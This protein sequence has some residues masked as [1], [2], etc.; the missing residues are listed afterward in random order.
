MHLIK[1]KNKSR[2]ED[3]YLITGHE[4]GKIV[5]W[6]LSPNQT[7]PQEYLSSSSNIYLR[8]YS[9]KYQMDNN[10]I[11]ILIPYRLINIYN[12]KTPLR[13]RNSENNTLSLDNSPE[14]PAKIMKKNVNLRQ[15]NR[16]YFSVDQKRMYS[17]TIAGE[18]HQWC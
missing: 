15:I 16:I 1:N 9:K 12:C 2:F 8:N 3:D 7:I 6:I 11:P 10:L 17:L 18:L 5:F 13:F 4:D 14:L